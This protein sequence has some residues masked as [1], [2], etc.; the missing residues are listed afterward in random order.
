VLLFAIIN[1]YLK[2]KE[3]NFLTGIYVGPE[4]P[5]EVPI[6]FLRNNPLPGYIALKDLIK[7]ARVYCAT[8]F[9]SALCDGAR[10]E[11]VRLS[12]SRV[13]TLRVP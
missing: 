13:S 3:L 2:N 1:K 4:A 9:D 12:G 5:T 11:V 10:R 6:T 7:R 8:H